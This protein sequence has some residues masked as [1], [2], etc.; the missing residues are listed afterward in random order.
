MFKTNVFRYLYSSTYFKFTRLQ[1]IN[2]KQL[3]IQFE[4]HYGITKSK[5][6][7]LLFNIEQGVILIYEWLD[8][9]QKMQQ[10]FW[11]LYFFCLNWLCKMLQMIFWSGKSRFY[12]FN[13]NA[14]NRFKKSRR[15]PRLAE[16]PELTL[17]LKSQLARVRGRW[18]IRLSL[19]CHKISIGHYFS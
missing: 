8:L 3:S 7:L 6:H 4:F 5:R 16:F 18:H 14:R 11:F 10:Y 12:F 1:Y 2:V 9:H 19:E 15:K 17:W 13:R